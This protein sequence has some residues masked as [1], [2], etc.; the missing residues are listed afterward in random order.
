MA[1]INCPVNA[2][3][4]NCCRFVA[5]L[6]PLVVAFTASASQETNAVFAARARNAFER[7]KVQFQ[8]N[9]NDADAGVQFARA[10][11]DW[12]DFATN[13]T[14]RAG[15]ARQGIA[16]CQKLLAHD[17]NSAPGHYY[18]AMNYGQLARAEAPSL[19]AYRLVRQIEREFQAAADLDK[20]ID[21]A[22]P[23][24][25]LGLLYRD[26]PGWPLSIGSNRK[27]RSY[28]EQSVKLAPDFPENRLNLVESDLQW[29]DSDG[30]KKELKA[31]DALWPAAQTNFNGET[32]EQ[33]WDDWSARRAAA[34]K[35]LGDLSAPAKQPK[36]GR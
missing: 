21:Y 20:T 22:G 14:Q 2:N 17:T 32:W 30:A 5:A 3:K 9:T 36:A 28:L 15:I 18:L 35:K 11:F 10:C 12:A 31:L 29:R 25:A 27:A 6:L 19:A 13:N 8:A 24:R 33:S 4:M 16:G 23:A 26:A 7:A 1:T 34:L